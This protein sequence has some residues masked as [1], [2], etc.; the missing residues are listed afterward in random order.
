MLHAIVQDK[1]K[2]YRRYIGHRDESDEKRIT[3][4]DEITSLILGPLKFLPPEERGRFW[5][6]LLRFRHAAGLPTGRIVDARMELWKRFQ[7]LKKS[8]EPD[9]MVYLICDDGQEVPVIVELKWRSPLSGADQLH[10][11][12]KH[13]L[14]AQGRQTGFHLFIAP[15]TS[16]A[17]AAKASVYGDPWGSRLIPADW[18]SIKGWLLHNNVFI[19]LE[20]RDWA[21]SVG[22][23]LE[24]LGIRA[25]KGFM[26]IAAPRIPTLPR[27]SVFFN[28]LH[29]W[30]HMKTE[31][32]PAIKAPV[33]FCSQ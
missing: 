19:T 8:V 3:A 22:L 20:G 26:G 30:N 32:V 11:Q 27:G 6:E 24:K 2:I 9:L 12:W 14:N 33:F 18:A 4:E 16:A 21:H 10:L 25:F 15:N 31:P 23:A 13:C 17:F 7:S 28:G 1:S 5:L 29:G